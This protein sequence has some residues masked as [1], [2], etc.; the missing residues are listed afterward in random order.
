[1][2]TGTTDRSGNR[3]P[4]IPTFLLLGAG[5][6]VVAVTVFR[7]SVAS[8]LSVGVLLICPLLMFGMHR[9]H[10]GDHR[11]HS[12]GPEHSRTDPAMDHE[13]EP[14]R[15]LRGR[16]IGPERDGAFGPSVR[17]RAQVLGRRGRCRP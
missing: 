9:G 1:M 8:V 2:T 3:R 17:G 14:P 4:T 12:S 5:L 6:I 10:A 13:G 7:V 15:G 16:L 11:G